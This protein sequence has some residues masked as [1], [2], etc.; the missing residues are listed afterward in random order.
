MCSKANR[1]TLNVATQPYDEVLII[2]ALFMTAQLTLETS[3][4]FYKREERD[5]ENMEFLFP[6]FLPV[7]FW[8]R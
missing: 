3:H 5:Y 6:R 4:Q 7:G 1:K 8:I 2:V